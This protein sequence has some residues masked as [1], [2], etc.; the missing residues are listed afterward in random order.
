[1]TDWRT[2]RYQYFRGYRQNFPILVSV[3]EQL[4][5][6][7]A[8]CLLA[9]N[10]LLCVKLLPLL[11]FGTAS[12][13]NERVNKRGSARCGYLVPFGTLLTVGM[14]ITFFAFQ[15]VKDQ[16]FSLQ[17][18]TCFTVWLRATS[19]ASFFLFLSFSGKSS[20]NLYLQN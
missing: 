7:T 13:P 10:G 6:K 18:K 14:K 8:F 1:M 15:H 17:R 3:S 9:V 4:Y 12:Y 16:K 20:V 5:L 2:C 11:T 19:T